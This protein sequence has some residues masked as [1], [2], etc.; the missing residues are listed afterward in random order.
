MSEHG[1][2]GYDRVYSMADDAGGT[3][4]KQHKELAERWTWVFYVTAAAG[5]AGMVAGWKW[6][7]VAVGN[8]LCRRAADGRLPRRRS[9]DCGLRRQGA[10]PRIPKK[11]GLEGIS[12]TCA[13]M[14]GGLLLV[15]LLLTATAVAGAEM[16][17]WTFQES[18]KTV[19]GED[20]GFTGD[21]VTLKRVDGKTFSVPVAYL[22]ETDRVFLVAAR[23]HQW[24]EVEVLELHGAES[25][26]RYKKCTVHGQGVNGDI[27]VERLPAAVEAILNARNQQAAPILVLSNR[28]KF[29]IQAAQQA[30]ASVP[31]G[32][33][34]YGRYGQAVRVERAEV[35]SANQDLKSAKTNL[36][37]L[38]K[39]YDDYVEKTRSQTIVTMRNSGVLYKTLAV[40]ECFD[41]RKPR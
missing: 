18:G 7:K 30:K 9:G 8:R 28:I 29:D 6:P 24:K 3:Y 23:A 16:R 36:A 13:L 37:Q 17:T 11:R 20:L 10:A 2:D 25:G 14:N 5:A 19:Q 41:P 26:G 12:R 31:A 39:S 15:G 27:L 34:P 35:K 1:E 21:A 40:W 4:L 33:S 32:A 38:Q 22:T